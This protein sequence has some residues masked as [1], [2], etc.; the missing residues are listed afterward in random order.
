MLTATMCTRTPAPRSPRA[1]ISQGDNRVL[2]R[3][4]LLW[5][6]AKRHTVQIAADD[7]EHG[8]AGA[9]GASPA[10]PVS[11]MAAA[12]GAA[13]VRRQQRRRRAQ[14]RVPAASEHGAGRR[15]AAGST[16]PAQPSQRSRPGRPAHL[17]TPPPCRPPATRA[18]APVQQR[19]RRRR[20][21]PV[22]QPGRPLPAL[23]AQLPDLQDRRRRQL[24]LPLHRAGRA[25]PQHRWAAGAP[26]N[27]QQ[28]SGAGVPPTR[29]AEGATW[30]RR[31]RRQAAVAG[32]GAARGAQAAA[33]GGAAAAPEPEVRAR[34][35]LA[36]P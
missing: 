29:M 15:C 14:Q 10:W 5:H 4:P 19:R 31:A 20:G 21:L 3:P 27:E 30:C 22:G 11:G 16:A 23:R 7:E 28:G 34:P 12:R 26:V 1:R 2:S 25:D 32:R 18:A 8:G 35:R 9:R 33:S 36:A 24:P 13:A 17:S 6:V